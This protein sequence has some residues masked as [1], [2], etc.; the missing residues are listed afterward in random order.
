MHWVPERGDGD[1]GGDDGGDDNDKEGGGG[2]GG[3]PSHKLVQIVWRLAGQTWLPEIGS[4]P[5]DR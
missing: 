2:A 1:D 5:V 4:R 3:E